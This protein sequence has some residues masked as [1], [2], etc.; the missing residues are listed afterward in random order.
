[1]LN[2][3]LSRLG[4]AGA[5][6]AGLA[7]NAAELKEGDAAP[8]FSMPGTDGKLHRLADYKGKQAVVVAW[9]PK[10]FTGG[11]TIE[12]KSMKEA[13]DAINRFDVAYFAASVDDPETNKKFAESLELDYPILSDPTLAAAK[14]FGVVNASRPVA[15]R[16]TFYIGKDGKVLLVDK[17]GNTKDH[18]AEIAAKLGELGV[19]K[20]SG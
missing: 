13:S 14:E 4:F 9:F 1:M 19:A 12:C 15:H 11:C 5:M 3:M 17:E 16:W 7:L 10:A 8:E 2:Q 20:K 18:G 6:L